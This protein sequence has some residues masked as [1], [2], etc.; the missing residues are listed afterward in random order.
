M[1]E[2]R[3]TGSGWIAWATF[4]VNWLTYVNSACDWVFY[5]VLNRDL[6]TLIRYVSNIEFK[7]NS[8]FFSLFFFRTLKSIRS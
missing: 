6:R 2:Q 4:I 1:F 8:R 5:A 3:E 7:Q